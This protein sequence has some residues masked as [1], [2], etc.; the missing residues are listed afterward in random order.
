MSTHTWD[1]KTIYHSDLRKLCKDE[2][3]VV[4]ML[5][6]NPIKSNYPG[7][8]PFV[9]FMI[10]GDKKCGEACCEKDKGEFRSYTYQVENDVVGEA[11]QRT[12]K[13]M[14]V[15]LTAVG[16]GDD[17]ELVFERVEGGPLT[18]HEIAR[19][20]GGSA[21]VMGYG[22]IADDYMHALEASHLIHE[23]WAETY[24]DEELTESIRACAYSLFAQAQRDGWEKPLHADIET[25]QEEQLEGAPSDADIQELLD[26]APITHQQRESIRESLADGL[27]N[28]RRITINTWL[29]QKIA[30]AESVPGDLFSPT[31]N[32]GSEVVN[33]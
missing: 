21:V 8:P 20:H 30:E 33:Q 6:A 22:T 26:E 3:H 10:K 4:L 29:K 23:W 27:D 24:P 19:S 25:P 5:N 31:T 28:A 2:G 11:V 13:K 18:S 15:R 32:Q 16:G 17:A 14:W 12:A 7:K 9:P 1:K